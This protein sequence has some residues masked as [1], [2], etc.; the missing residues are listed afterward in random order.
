MHYILR[1]KS[2]ECNKL[3]LIHQT[4][5]Q[6]LIFQH[7]KDACSVPRHSRSHTK[8]CTLANRVVYWRGAA[9]TWIHEHASKLVLQPCPDPYHKA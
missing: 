3:P 9:A 8:S 2:S 5:S 6:R 7:P 4:L 1:C